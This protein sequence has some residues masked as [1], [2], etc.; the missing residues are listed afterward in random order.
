M[1]FFDDMSPDYFPDPGFFTEDKEPEKDWENN[2][3]LYEPFPGEE[4]WDE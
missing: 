3:P 1:D 2:N 4:H